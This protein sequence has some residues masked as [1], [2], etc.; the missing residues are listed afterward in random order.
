[1]SVLGTGFYSECTYSGKKETTTRFVQR[2]SLEEIDAKSWE[3][4]DVALIL[5]TQRAREENWR[6][7]SPKRRNNRTKQEEDYGDLHRSI[8]ELGLTC[9]VKDIAIKNGND[10]AEIWEIFDT[11]Y[12]LIEQDDELYL[13]LTHGFRSL[14]MLLLVLVNYVKFMK[15]AKVVYLSYGNFEAVK[16]GVAPII[17]L[18]PFAKLQDWTTA[19]SSFKESG[20]VEVLVDT[21]KSTNKRLPS[22]LFDLQKNLVA[23]QLQLE[24]CCGKQICEGEAAS[25][26]KEIIAK[27]L[28]DKSLPAPTDPILHSITNELESFNVNSILNI[29]SALQWCKKYG[30]VQQGYILCQEGIVTVIC[31]RMKDYNPYSDDGAARCYRDYWSSIL[32]IG[33]DKFRD[34]SKW[35]G[36]LRNNLELTRAIFALDW[37][38]NLRKECYSKIIAKRNHVAHAG[39]VGDL[40]EK[41]IKKDFDSV[42]DYCIGFFDWDLTP[43]AAS[44]TVDRPAVF[45]NLSNHPAETWSEEQKNAAGQYGGMEEIPFPNIAPD[46]DTKAMGEI[47]EGI[48][49]QIKKIAEGKSVTVHVMGE[50]TFTY[51]LVKR[52][53]GMGVRCVAS[54]T[55]REVVDNGDGTRTTKFRFVKFRDYE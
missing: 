36:S 48:F 12:G 53:K 35:N 27:V 52:L 34:E 41:Q 45:I 37:V 55:N 7:D 9:Q 25:K 19:A 8:S 30:L 26:V 44:E 15:N 18:L 1:M 23:F 10:E 14:P 16:D 54:T 38:Q 17:N 42:I 3:A 50:M 31:E 49:N 5:L 28:Q 46:V 22:D 29:K 4:D 21:I 47:V 24:T 43:P 32:G 11:I 20:R 51:A 2:A 13:D 6:R 40:K 39:F 33:D